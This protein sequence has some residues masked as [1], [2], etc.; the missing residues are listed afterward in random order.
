MSPRPAVQPTFNS[1]R[2][3][4]VQPGFAC[5]NSPCMLED[6]SDP[7]TSYGRATQGWDVLGCAVS[8]LSPLF[9]G[10]RSTE[11]SLLTSF[12]TYRRREQLPLTCPAFA[13]ACH[14][15]IWDS[16]RVDPRQ[17]REQ[18]Y[19]DMSWERVQPWLMKRAGNISGIELRSVSF[20]SL[21]ASALSGQAPSVNACLSACMQSPLV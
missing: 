9:R 14:D 16:V 2:A 4:A 12:L 1:C 19:A 5:W 6:V 10:M 17:Y 13:A 8:A 18:T 21:E 11:A 3:P 20:L 15:I 7:H